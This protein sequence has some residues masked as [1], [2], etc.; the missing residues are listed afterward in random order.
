MSELVGAEEQHR[1]FL[2]AALRAASARAKMIEADINTVGVALRGNMIDA[3]TAVRW[4]MENGLTW[5]V[6][7][8]PSEVGRVANPIEN[9]PPKVP[10]KQ[11]KGTP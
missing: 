9:E 3:E 4:I 7:P 1:E 8:M 2:L 11:R 5:I 10:D 6:G